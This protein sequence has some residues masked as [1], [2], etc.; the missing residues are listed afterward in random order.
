METN[1]WHGSYTAAS[2]ELS[3]PEPPEDG[4]LGK[5]KG[6]TGIAPFGR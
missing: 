2:G 4:I 3:H 5:V 1:T 6:A